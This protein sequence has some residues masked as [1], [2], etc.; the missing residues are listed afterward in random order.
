MTARG[1]EGGG[2]RARRLVGAGNKA[3]GWLK[4]VLGFYGTAV[5]VVQLLPAALALVAVFVTPTAWLSATL[6]RWVGLGALA[7]ALVGMVVLAR[8]AG[9]RA[10]LGRGDPVGRRSGR[11]AGLAWWGLGVGVVASAAF[12]LHL[13]VVDVSFVSSV[14]LLTPLLDFYLGGGRAAE[15]LYN[16][17][18]AALA[19]VALAGLASGAPAGLLRWR[20]ARRA[21][22]E[23]LE[24]GGAL[25][26]LDEALASL[27]SARS[28][29]EAAKAQVAGMAV[30]LA[31]LRAAAGRDAPGRTPGGGV[32]APAGAP[33]GKPGGD[34][35][36][37]PPG[38]TPAPSGADGPATSAGDRP[39]RRAPRAADGR[40]HR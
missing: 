29:V 3:Y 9:P 28:A 18:A 5:T 40:A 25:A 11:L 16:A 39:G 31:E 30:E 24:E 1:T 32:S 2:G 6:R 22:R 14:P 15:T 21:R 4:G 38:E 12:R 7:G 37:A 13:A 20:E 17:L 23:L 26:A 33:A 27:A 19:G 35:A 34:A 8:A 10:L 36:S